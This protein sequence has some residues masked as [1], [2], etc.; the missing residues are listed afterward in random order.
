MLQLSEVWQ[1]NFQLLPLG[2]AQT[3]L[4]EKQTQV[5][6]LSSCSQPYLFPDFGTNLEFGQRLSEQK[7]RWTKPSN[8]KY[9]YH[10]ITVL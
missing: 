5:N 4:S 9:Y 3:S 8:Y 1:C 10:S 6:E 2:W 7:Q